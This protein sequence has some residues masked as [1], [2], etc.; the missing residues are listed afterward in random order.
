MPKFIA[1][2]LIGTLAFGQAHAV[3][4]SDAT[5]RLQE[6]DSIWMLEMD[7]PPS[8]IETTMSSYLDGELLRDLSRQEYNREILEYVRTHFRLKVD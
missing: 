7:L 5:F 8:G 6:K 1:F 2:L 3:G 4:G